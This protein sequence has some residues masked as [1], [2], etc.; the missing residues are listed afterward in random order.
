MIL[1]LCIIINILIIIILIAFI[2]HDG[3]FSYGLQIKSI[4]II[5]VMI[6]LAGF[7]TNNHINNTEQ[8]I[9]KNFSYE[10]ESL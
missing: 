6:L 9:F 4:I 10:I 1:N 7:Y 5:F 3:R 2:K 8:K